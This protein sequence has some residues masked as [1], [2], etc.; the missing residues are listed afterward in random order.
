M[1]ILEKF[2]Y[3]LLNFR[4]LILTEQFQHKIKQYLIIK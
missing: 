3:F 1:V 4:V 2:L